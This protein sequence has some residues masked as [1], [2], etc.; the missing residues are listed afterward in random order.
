MDINTKRNSH[1]WRE[2]TI[3][4]FCSSISLYETETP[5][6]E[7]IWAQILLKS[8]IWSTKNSVFYNFINRERYFSQNT[9]LFTTSFFL[10]IWTA[11]LNL[12]N[13][14]HFSLSPSPHFF[15]CCCP[16]FSPPLFH[17]A[18]Q[19]ISDSANIRK[20]PCHK[21]KAT[22]MSVNLFAINSLFNR[23]CFEEIFKE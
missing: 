20:T 19:T 21:K 11:W 6:K 8:Q 14:P 2:F 18:P 15:C 9:K 22:V 17:S 12:T 1:L 16:S 5:M 10:Q 13:S 4:P 3:N 23:F 7:T